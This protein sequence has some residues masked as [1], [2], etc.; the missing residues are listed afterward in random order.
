MLRSLSL[1]R[2]LIVAALLIVA[3]G[4]AL[5]PPPFARISGLLLDTRLDEISGLAASRHHDN[6]LWV[7]NDGG[8]DAQLYAINPRG[9]VR[10]SL[11]IN[12]VPNTDWEDMA[13]FSLDGHDY[14]LVADTG[15][16]GGLRHTLQ[17]HVI[18]E[19][20]E[21]AEGLQA[22]PVWSIAFRWPDGARDCE[23]VAVDV[24]NGRILLLS[25]KRRPAQLFALPL[26]PD[27]SEVQVA[28]LLGTLAGIPQADVEERR[29]DPE[30]ARL[31]GQV[32]AADLSPDG[33]TLAVMT[34]DHV[35]LYPRVDNE[36][37]ANAVSRAPRVH[38]LSLLPQA[39]ALGWAADGHGLY[40]TGEFVPAPL[41]LLTPRRAAPSRDPLASR[42]QRAAAR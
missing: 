33:R 37:L 32:T 34:Y 17:L 10:G 27:G 9:S 26:K 11:T 35:L 39:E 42:L 18:E 3:G 8:S 15:D 6:I 22:Q 28:T 20:A 14:L 19:P 30:H 41:L 13:A 16:N 40:A 2:A 36:T 1:C 4:C 12:G 23:A 29:N 21:L 31:R 25:K 5:S 7:H 38:E 24:T